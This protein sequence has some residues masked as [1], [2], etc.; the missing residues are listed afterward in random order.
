MF[1][2][3]LLTFIYPNKCV[4]CDKI[5][6]FSNKNCFCDKC[7][8]N[9]DIVPRSE[10]NDNYALFYYND[11]MRHVIH[12]FK[13]NNNPWCGPKLGKL[14]ADEFVKLSLKADY[15]CAVPM[16]YKKQRKRGFNQ[17]DIIAS[18][19]SK[20]S[21][22]PILKNTLI[23]VKDTIPQSK[24]GYKE[25][26][27]NVKNAFSVKK[28]NF[29]NGKTIALIDD[30]YT[31][32]STVKSCTNELIKAGAKRVFSFCLCFSLFQEDK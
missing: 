4:L 10:D 22:I 6:N 31:T 18:E 25:R 21:G 24:L 23:R 9:I 2:F 28:N 7:A 17:S 11:T 16:F 14:M 13:F 15:I 12:K 8:K 19:I 27:E 30:I 3:N 26:E 32:G 20:V 1:L 5:L 29:L